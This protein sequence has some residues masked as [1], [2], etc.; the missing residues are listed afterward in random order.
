MKLKP[1]TYLRDV[2]DRFDLLIYRVQSK[3]AEIATDVYNEIS[4]NWK[5]DCFYHSLRVVPKCRDER[6]KAYRKAV[7]TETWK[8]KKA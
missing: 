6:I 2:A 3:T 5:D 8:R 1:Y 7:A 4:G